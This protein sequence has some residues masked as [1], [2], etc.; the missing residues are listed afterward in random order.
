[1]RV[2]VVTRMTRPNDKYVSV[3]MNKMVVMNVMLEVK[4]F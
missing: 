1:M 2:L 4:A 3:S